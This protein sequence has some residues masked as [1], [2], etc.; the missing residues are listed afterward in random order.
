M[1]RAAAAVALALA[2]LAAGCDPGTPSTC[3]DRAPEQGERPGDGLRA[4]TASLRR[5]DLGRGWQAV[6]RGQTIGVLRPDL[7]GLTETGRF[8]SAVFARAGL[9]ARSTT[10]L[11]ESARDAATA[12]ERA[13][14]NDYA[15][16]LGLRLR[17]PGGR[18]QRGRD[19]VRVQLRVP[20]AAEAGSDPVEVM[21][22]SHGRA[23]VVLELVGD[24]PPALERRLLAH[25]RMRLASV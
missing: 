2:A 7:G 5:S 11:F 1:R 25:L 15:D 18:S 12:L 13:T 19:V 23:V 17:A 24:F 3:P 6:H 22:V 8:D 20:R 14:T 21:L 9:V 4:R 16:C 10:S